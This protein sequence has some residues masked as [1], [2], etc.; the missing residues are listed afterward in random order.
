MLFAAAAVAV[1]S[2]LSVTVLFKANK[3]V[4]NG[5][6]VYTAE[7]IM[8]AGGFSY[9]V[10][11]IRFNTEEAEKNIADKLVY[12]DSVKIAKRF[13]NQITVEAANAKPEVVLFA[14]GRY[15]RISGKSRILEISET[16]PEL[17]E[18]P[19]V[20]GYSPKDREVGAYL[21]SEDGDEG[22]TKLIFELTALAKEHN[23]GDTEINLADKLDVSLTCGGRVSIKLGA[24]TE[25][26]EKF[27]VAEKM[28]ESYI[29][30]SEKGVLRLANPRKVTFK[31]DLA[32]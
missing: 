26:G 19:V 16:R 9:G 28:L 32:G 20:V 29:A 14:D 31:P 10:N 24:P 13:P 17:D 5:D 18:N 22:K 21:V 1:V 27:T 3:V 12:I 7:Q 8:E 2:F 11:L 30:P 6:C 23:L 25:L 15:Y 4:I